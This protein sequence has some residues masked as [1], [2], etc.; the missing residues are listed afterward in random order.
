MISSF[1]E[2]LN[3]TPSF[4]IFPLAYC[5]LFYI[6]QHYLLYFPIFHCRQAPTKNSPL[7]R[8]QKIAHSGCREEGLPE[9]SQAAFAHAIKNDAN[10]IECD[11]WLTLDNEVVVFHDENLKEM[12]GVEGKIADLNYEE[13]PKLN[14]KHNP[15]Q[16]FACHQYS[17]DFVTKIPRFQEVL[18]LLPPDKMINVEFKQHSWKLIQKVHTALA[19]QHFLKRQQVFWFSLEEKMNKDL[20]KADPTIPTVVSIEGLLKVLV[21]YYLGVLPFVEIDDAVFGI[22]LEEVR[23]FLFL[24]FQILT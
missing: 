17:T 20:R 3:L 13:L 4:H 9:N 15:K 18:D 5:I 7:L 16:H 19:N 23:C 12:C 2:Y 22:T 21:F 1:I 6:F 10:V 11:V 24:A 8:A 14:T